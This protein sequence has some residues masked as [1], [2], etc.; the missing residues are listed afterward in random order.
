MNRKSHRNAPSKMITRASL[1]AGIMILV[2]VFSPNRFAIG[3][4]GPPSYACDLQN[5]SG[6]KIEACAARWEAANIR[7]HLALTD[8]LGPESVQCLKD[9]ADALDQSAARMLA[10]NRH[11]D[12]ASPACELAATFAKAADDA[13]TQVC[14]GA[15][16]TYNNSEN[17]KC[18]FNQSS[19]PSLMNWLV[20]NL[21]ALSDHRIHDPNPDAPS[22]LKCCWSYSLQFS[23]DGCIAHIE[24]DV[25]IG[26]YTQP[27]SYT[28]PLADVTYVNAQPEPRFDGLD[29]IV[30]GGTGNGFLMHAP[31]YDVK[32]PQEQLDWFTPANASR[33]VDQLMKTA[34]ACKR[35]QT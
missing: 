14:P 31:T 21:P 33:V 15:V 6:V 32:V 10:E 11:V 24:D 25:T 22:F 19:L 13:L 18:D 27:Y 8:N 34:A 9:Y 28:I 20:T 2:S 29:F 3:A 17:V 4:T 16:W 1:Y 7:A 30:I 5:G 23:A 12:I 26:G 35:S